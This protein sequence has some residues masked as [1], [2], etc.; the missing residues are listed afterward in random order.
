MLPEK[1]REAMVQMLIRPEVIRT[2]KIKKIFS[3]LKLGFF[4]NP[5]YGVMM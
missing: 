4:S 1:H 2:F 5:V 3:F